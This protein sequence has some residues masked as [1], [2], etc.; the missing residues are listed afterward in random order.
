MLP[1]EL[2]CSLVL[3][4]DDPA[5]LSAFYAA[6]LETPACPG[7]SRSHWRLAWPGGGLLE[8]FRPSRQRPLARGGGR[9]A[10]CLSRQAAGPDPLGELQPW[11]AQVLALGADAREPPR[12]ESFGAEAWV[13]DP[14]QNRLLL[15]VSGA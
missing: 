13:A 14:E 9:L 12:R 1:P 11:Y 6:L 15:L 5:R 7:L 10:F 3:A 8:I 2:S 4:A